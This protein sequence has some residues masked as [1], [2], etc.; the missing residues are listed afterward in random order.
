[1][2]IILYKTA[3]ANGKPVRIF[4]SFRET[5]SSSQRFGTLHLAYK[6]AGKLT[7]AGCY[8]FF[9]FVIRATDGAVVKQHRHS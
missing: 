2:Y 1:M 5:A 8:C 6:T 4:Y 7:P 3:R 9:Y